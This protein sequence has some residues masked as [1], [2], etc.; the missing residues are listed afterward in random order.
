LLPSVIPA[1]DRTELER[2]PDPT[3]ESLL[4]VVPFSKL[5]GFSGRRVIASQIILS[6]VLATDEDFE[7][8][9][10]VAAC[11]AAGILWGVDVKL[12]DGRYSSIVQNVV[13]NSI[14]R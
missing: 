1:V 11:I 10:F 3:K 7:M 4:H 12:N 2:L 9:A 8:K 13:V 6:S 5:A 14:P